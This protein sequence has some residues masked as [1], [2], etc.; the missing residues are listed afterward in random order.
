MAEKLKATNAQLNQLMM[1][2][3]QD[4]TMEAIL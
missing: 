3:T 4:P 2:K 1:E